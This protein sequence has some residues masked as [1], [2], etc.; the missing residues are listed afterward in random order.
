MSVKAIVG[1]VASGKSTKVFEQIRDILDN[2]ETRVLLITGEY[3]PRYAMDKIGYS[4]SPD[5]NIVDHRWANIDGIASW[6]LMPNPS[7]QIVYIDGM[8]ID[9][10]ALMLIESMANYAE[11]DVVV[12]MQTPR[13]TPGNEVMQCEVVSGRLVY[14]IEE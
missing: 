9:T 2:D 6:L 1:P 4:V 5:L 12:T 10:K 3:E 8:R 11:I 14:D 13:N 7:F